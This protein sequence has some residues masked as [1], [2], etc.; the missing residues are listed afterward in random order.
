MQLVT[1]RGWLGGRLGGGHG[2]RDVVPLQHNR[3]QHLPQSR[4]RADQFEVL[5]EDRS[6]HAE[7]EGVDEAWTDAD[8]GDR[9]EFDGAAPACVRTPAYARAVRAAPHDPEKLAVGRKDR[10]RGVGQVSDQEAAA[11]VDRNA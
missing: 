10:D 1:H 9:F 2:E 3:R 6:P 5:V 11:V 7:V 4:V 8:V